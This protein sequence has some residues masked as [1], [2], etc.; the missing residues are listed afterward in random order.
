MLL[1]AEAAPSLLRCYRA[2]YQSAPC[3]NNVL[4]ASLVY[5]KHRGG[6]R[7]WSVLSIIH[8]K[9]VSVLTSEVMKTLRMH[10]HSIRSFSFHVSNDVNGVKFGQTRKCTS[11]ACSPAGREGI[12][13]F[14][15][16][17]SWLAQQ[18]SPV[19][20]PR[21]NVALPHVHRV[22]QSKVFLIYIPCPGHGQYGSFIYA[23]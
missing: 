1:G 13:N 4:P 19:W 18:N 14:F 5:N 21:C 15:Q 17:Q 16:C 20:S 7:H 9:L 10:R 2:S 11:A 22:I 23:K 6:D 3:Q 12:R 8:Q